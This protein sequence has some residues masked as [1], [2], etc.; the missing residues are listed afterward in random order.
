MKYTSL[1]LLAA[2]ATAE[3][4]NSVPVTAKQHGWTQGNPS[5]QVH[6]TLFYDM[7]CPESKAAYYD[8]KGMMDKESPV[9]GLK[10]SELVNMEIVPFVFAFHLHSW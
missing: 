2:T 9:N 6:I 8:W 7:L 5:G 3:F 10:Y 4:Q 1:A